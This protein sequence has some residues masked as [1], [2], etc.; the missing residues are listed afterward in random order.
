M[1]AKFV[2]ERTDFLNPSCHMAADR[3]RV[4]K[5]HKT[6]ALYNSLCSIWTFYKYDGPTRLTGEGCTC[7]NVLIFSLFYLTDN[8]GGL[9]IYKFL[10]DKC[11][12]TRQ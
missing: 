10:N 9:Q 11:K 7:R 4:S 5:A 8:V 3:I 12:H 2:R 6:T 1:C